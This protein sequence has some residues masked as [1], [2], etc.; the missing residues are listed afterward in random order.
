MQNNVKFDSST[1]M[2]NK[3]PGCYDSMAS[4]YEAYR[5]GMLIGP[6]LEDE[7]QEIDVLI[8]LEELG[9]PMQETGTY[10]YKDIIIKAKQEL[11]KYIKKTQ[12]QKKK[13]KPI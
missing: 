7:Q 12:K 8:V 2:M 13:Q 4:K 9:Y 3:H 5:C 10:F 6:L 11:Q 1:Y